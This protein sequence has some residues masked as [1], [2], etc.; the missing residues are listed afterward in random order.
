LVSLRDIERLKR[1]YHWLKDNLPL[2]SKIFDK[3][4]VVQ[5]NYQNKPMRAFIVA[6]GLVYLSR[7]NVKSKRDYVINIVNKNKI[8]SV[9][10]EYN[11]LDF[12]DIQTIKKF[13]EDD[14]LFRLK[15][16]Y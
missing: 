6:L 1:V 14:F 4:K 15:I 7:L 12:D 10:D 16:N 2:E 11:C 9:I 3:P 5:K 8:S 13:E